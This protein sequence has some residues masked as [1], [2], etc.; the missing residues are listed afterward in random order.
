MGDV[1]FGSL[2]FRLE[3]DDEDDDEDYHVSVDDILN[4][5]FIKK[6]LFLPIRL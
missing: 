6:N 1:R 2:H 4:T 5:F 3:E